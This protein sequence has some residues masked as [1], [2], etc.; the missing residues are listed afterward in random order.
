MEG[1]FAVIFVII[2]IVNF[3]MK[4]QQNQ[5]QDQGGMK[6]QQ[7]RN[8]QYPSQ[9]PSYKAQQPR[10]TVPEYMPSPIW[11]EESEG[12]EAEDRRIQGSL[13]Y[14]EQSQSS[15]GIELELP[16][17]DLRKRKEKKPVI[18]AEVMEREEENAIFEITEYNLLSSIIMA[19]IIGPPRSMKRS[20]R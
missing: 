11:V 17:P 9:Q 14:V 6:K 10:K 8:V 3:V 15:E 12:I 13:N 4:Q 16:K 19:E 20:I 18:K 7:S 2:G 5:N 1:L